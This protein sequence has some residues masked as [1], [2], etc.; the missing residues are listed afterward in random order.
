V[1]Y[2]DVVEVRESLEDD[3]F[4]EKQ[5]VVEH[6]AL[7]ALKCVVVTRAARR[8]QLTRSQER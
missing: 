3:F 1:A 5:L 8:L 2:P 7:T 4:T 6:S